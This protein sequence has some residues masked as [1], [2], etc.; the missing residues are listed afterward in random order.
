MFKQNKQFY[1]GLAGPKMGIT[2]DGENYIIKFPKNIRDKKDQF[3]TGL[4]YSNSPVSRMA[5]RIYR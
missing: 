4:S 1:G 2:I 5:F 3:R